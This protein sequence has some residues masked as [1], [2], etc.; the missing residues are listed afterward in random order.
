[1]A[2]ARAVVRTLEGVA[3]PDEVA[4]ARAQASALRPRPRAAGLAEPL[5]VLT[6]AEHAAASRFAPAE[7]GTSPP[8]QAV[9]G[10]GEARSHRVPSLCRSRRREDLRRRLAQEKSCSPLPSGGVT[11]KAENSTSNP[12]RSGVQHTG[13][14]R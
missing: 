11:S 3:T 1:V 9:V 6:D 4:R 12:A 2:H 8:R 10:Y 14:T 13:P 7:A 5:A